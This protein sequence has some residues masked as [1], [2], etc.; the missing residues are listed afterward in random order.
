MIV[1]PKTALM[2]IGGASAAGRRSRYF[3]NTADSSQTDHAAPKKAAS[4]PNGDTEASSAFATVRKRIA[5][6]PIVKAKSLTPAPV[7]SRNSF[8]RPAR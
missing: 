1:L 5:G 6:S 4:T 2:A 8:T 7:S 3:V